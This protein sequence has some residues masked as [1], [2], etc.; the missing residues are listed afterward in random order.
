MKPGKGSATEEKLA[1]WAKV[2][3]PLPIEFRLARAVRIVPVSDTTITHAL[4]QF[5]TVVTRIET[6]RGRE[7]RDGQIVMSWEKNASDDATC[8]ACDSRTFCPEY[9]KVTVPRLPKA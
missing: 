6:C 2:G 1:K 3:D 7:L 5:D 9:A 4:D 8:V